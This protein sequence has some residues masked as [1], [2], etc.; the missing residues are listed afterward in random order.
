MSAA[1]VDSRGKVIQLD[2]QA[3][4]DENVTEQD[5]ADVSK[6]SKLLARLMKDVAA[7]VGRFQPKRIDF[8]DIDVDDTG[9]TLYR[10]EHGFGRRVCWWVVD[11]DD[12][13]VLSRDASSTN[14]TL[15]LVS[16]AVARVT[17]RVE[18]AG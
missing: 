18:A 13:A 7:V 5:V 3:Q 17:I 8:E 2:R 11:S 10:F 6:L 12:Q 14:D 15:V 1:R 16:Y 9:S 4:Q